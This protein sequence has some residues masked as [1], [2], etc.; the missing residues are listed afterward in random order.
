MS[1]TNG[2]VVKNPGQTSEIPP[3]SR[4]EERAAATDPS[5][6]VAHTPAHTPAHV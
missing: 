2:P 3:A 1:I 6:A 4:T 5:H